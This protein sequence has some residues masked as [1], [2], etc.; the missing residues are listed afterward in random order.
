MPSV[1]LRN[2]ICRRSSSPISSMRERA[3]NMSGGP[4]TNNTH[5]PRTMM[6]GCGTRPKR[7]PATASIFGT[8]S[9]LGA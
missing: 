2:P 6:A 7:V 3:L 9:W 4:S 8:R 1:R 5:A